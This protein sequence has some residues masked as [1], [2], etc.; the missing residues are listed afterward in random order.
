MKYQFMY[1]LTKV[2]IKVYAWAVNRVPLSEKALNC[3]KEAQELAHVLL[4]DDDPKLYALGMTLAKVN[5][6]ALLR[7]RKEA[8]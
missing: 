3:I 4:E 2:T 8:L 7:M 5:A 6:N 1:L